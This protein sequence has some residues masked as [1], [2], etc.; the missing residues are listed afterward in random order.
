MGKEEQ[1]LSPG[2][3]VHCMKGTSENSG[4]YQMKHHCVLFPDRVLDSSNPGEF[5]TDTDCPYN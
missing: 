4:W 2:L 3:T 5:Q 1:P